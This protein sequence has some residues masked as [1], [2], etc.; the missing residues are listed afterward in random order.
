VPSTCAG[1][2]WVVVP[3]VEKSMSAIELIR[4]RRRFDSESLIAIG[5]LLARVACYQIIHT[6]GE[7]T[8][9][10]LLVLKRTRP[11]AI[12]RILARHSATVSRRRTLWLLDRRV[13]EVL[14]VTRSDGGST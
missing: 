13:R 7:P 11:P 14:N 8:L 5:K 9:P 1:G 10:S 6:D 12:V 3:Y 2:V 4:G